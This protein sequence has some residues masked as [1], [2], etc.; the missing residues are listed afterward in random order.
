MRVALTG[1]T[2]F[3]GPCL[4]QR[5]LAHGHQVLALVRSPE[6]AR[7]RLPAGVQ[8]ARWDADGPLAPE[9]LAG[10]EGVVHLAGEPVAQRWSHDAKR[11]ILHSREASTR[12]LVAA[13]AASGSVRHFVSASAVGFYGD[14]G[15]T[16]VTEASAPG[17]GFLADVCRTW[18]A[19]AWR[20]RDAGLR[21]AVVRI[22]VVLHPAGGAL[23]E[24]LPLF[25]V[26]AGGRAG[27]GKQWVPWVHRDDA[28]AL[29]EWALVSEGV[30]GVLAAVAPQPVRQVE[31]AHALGHALHRPSFVH[32]PAFALRL[33]FGEMASVVLEGQ[34][35]LPERTL[36]LGFQF[37]FPTLD[38]ALA[39]LLPSGVHAAHAPAS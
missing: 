10:V 33:R 15:D 23:K 32:A 8:L 34:R 29:L 17:A 6:R 31:L 12:H 19:E 21:T 38:G 7:A 30:D 1:A 9:V 28:V 36:A 27:S 16:P 24:L 35:V 26:G 5:L 14:R 13:M 18:E 20:A 39:D 37:R 2:G 3:L 4:A 25:R 22:G 11:R